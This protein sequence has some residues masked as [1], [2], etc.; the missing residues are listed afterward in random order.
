MEQEKSSNSPCQQPLEQLIS[1][2]EDNPTN[3]DFLEQLVTNNPNC[4]DELAN[5]FLLWN[6]LETIEQPEPRPEMSS[7]FYKKLNEY[8]AAT[9][10]DKIPFWKKLF[11]FSIK[12][13]LAYGLGFGLFLLGFFSG[14]IF[15]PDHQ[16]AQI[17]QLAQQINDLKASQ[18]FQLAPK[19]SVA[20]RM[21]NIQLVRNIEN[22][23]EKILNALNQALCNDPNINVRLSAIETLLYFADDPM[24]IEILIKAI[25]KQSSALVQL[26]LA[27]VMLQLE[28]KRSAKAWKELLEKGEVELEVKMQLEESL[29]KWM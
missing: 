27:E 29:E 9:A 14:Q 5:T 12:P 18:A 2:L 28:E 15:Q 26:E 11:K 24:V 13:Q 1:Q 19:Q 21:K 17:D 8:Q 20:D 23:N 16:Q 4:A 3:K 22:P 10:P 6:E 7:N 25:P